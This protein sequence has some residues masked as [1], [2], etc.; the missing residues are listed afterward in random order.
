MWGF[1]SSPALGGAGVYVGGLDARVYAF[2][3]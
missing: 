3:F 2:D 1:A